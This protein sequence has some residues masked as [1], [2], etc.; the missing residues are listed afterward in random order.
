MHGVI[1]QDWILRILSGLYVTLPPIDY[2]VK[3]KLF[4]VMYS[5][6]NGFVLQIFY[7][8][9]VVVPKCFVGCQ[10]SYCNYQVQCGCLQ[11]LVWQE[12]C[13]HKFCTKWASKCDGEKLEYEHSLFPGSKHRD[14]YAKCNNKVIC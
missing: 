4:R 9:H 2:Y 7:L 1:F 10:F 11:N 3:T 6:C 14:L 5:L 12:M 8:V 13:S